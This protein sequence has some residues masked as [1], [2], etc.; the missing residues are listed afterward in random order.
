MHVI[1]VVV[2]EQNRLYLTH[3]SVDQL[4][5][6]LR[7]GV[8]EDAD[9][10]IGLN[11]GADATA[12]VTRIARPAHLARAPNLGDAKTGSRPQEGEFQTVSTLR[13][14]VVPGMSNGTPAVTMMRSP[15]VAS[16]RRTTTVLVR[17]IISS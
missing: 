17:S 14:L 13:R 6:Q 7:R 5:S 15:L 16:S 10:A 2:G 8:D 12:L 4:K 1:S 11:K 9:A 3:A